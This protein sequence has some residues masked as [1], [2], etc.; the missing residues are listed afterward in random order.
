MAIAT[1]TFY[2]GIPGAGQVVW[3]GLSPNWPEAVSGIENKE[4]R[5]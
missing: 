5:Q 2:G 3:R 1:E 4:E